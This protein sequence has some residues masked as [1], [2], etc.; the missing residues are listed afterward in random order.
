L[1]DSSIG[2]LL[3][4]GKRSGFE[5]VA[6]GFEILGPDQDGELIPKTDW[7]HWRSFPVFAMNV[8]RYLGGLRVSLSSAGVAPGEPMVLRSRL[9]VKQVQ[10]DSPSGQRTRI[11]ARDKVNFVFGGTEEL[12]V[13]SVREGDA[14]KL[15]QHF[16]VNLFDSRESNLTPSPEIEL[17]YETVAG[18]SGTQQGRKE[19]WKILL[20]AALGVLIFEWYV[21]NRRVYL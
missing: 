10:I 3:V 11:T 15:T 8:L 16:A 19:L 18:Q 6:I 13:Y 5:D 2:S 1:F 20:L 7:P 12:G 21:Y 14:R 17:G 4:I 9:A